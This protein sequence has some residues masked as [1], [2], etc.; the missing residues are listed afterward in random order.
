M[1]HR[2]RIIASIGNI[3][4][5][6]SDP[7]ARSYTQTEARWHNRFSTGSLNLR[8]PQRRTDTGRQRN[9]RRHRGYMTL[10]SGKGEIK[11]CVNTAPSSG[12]PAI[13]AGLC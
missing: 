1:G 7:E 11:S 5:T 12:M 3:S 4:S 9:V 2:I 13:N 6:S 10:N 8:L